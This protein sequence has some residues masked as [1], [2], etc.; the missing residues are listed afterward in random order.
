MVS[1]PHKRRLGVRP[2]AQMGRN[3][4]AFLHC[5]ASQQILKLYVRFGSKAD[6][7]ALRSHVR[8]TPESGHPI[9]AFL[10]STR[11]SH[12]ATGIGIYP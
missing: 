2:T 12:A 10:M 3:N 11:P 7:G 9:C 8:F 1:D 4:N 6:A 5:C